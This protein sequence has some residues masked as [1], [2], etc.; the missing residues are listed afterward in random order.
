ML[1]VHC[2]AGQDISRRDRVLL[3]ARSQ[4]VHA[5]AA[6]GAREAQTSS[7]RVV[8]EVND[9]AATE[10]ARRIVA[11]VSGVK[12]S[13]ALNGVVAAQPRGDGRQNGWHGLNGSRQVAKDEAEARKVVV[14]ASVTAAGLVLAAMSGAWAVV[15]VEAGEFETSLGGVIEEVA[16]GRCPILRQISDDPDAASMLLARLAA[17]KAAP[18]PRQV[19]NPLTELE[20]EILSLISRGHTS[21]RIAEEM[22]FQLQTVKNKV[23]AIL[24][25]TGARTR[26]QAAAQAQANGW[27]A[28]AHAGRNGSGV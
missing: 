17:A 5:I 13:F 20:T 3:L 22:G 1:S 28:P 25:K 14:N 16:A 8:V 6:N 2:P 9:P 12:V 15:T 4:L 19:P 10:R 24:N 7:V 23:T 18:E 21:R 11:S 26:G 27:I